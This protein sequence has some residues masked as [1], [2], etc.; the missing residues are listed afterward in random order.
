MKVYLVTWYVI[1]N[2]NNSI[3][4]SSNVGYSLNCNIENIQI[5]QLH[6]LLNKKN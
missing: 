6:R 3:G 1:T 4:V 2:C 5:I